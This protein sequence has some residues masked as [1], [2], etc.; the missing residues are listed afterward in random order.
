MDF[1]H[2][3]VRCV[4]DI[5]LLQSLTQ[6]GIFY[7]VYVTSVVAVYL[8]LA[9]LGGANSLTR[10]H[11]HECLGSCHPA[12]VGIEVGDKLGLYYIDDVAILV[13]CYVSR[14]LEQG[15]AWIVHLL[16]WSHLLVKTREAQ[17]RLGCV[18]GLLW[19]GGEVKPKGS[20]GRIRLSSWCELIL[21]SQWCR[22]SRWRWL[23]PPHVGLKGV[24]VGKLVPSIRG[25]RIIYRAQVL[26]LAHILC[27]LVDVGYFVP[28]GLQRVVE[29]R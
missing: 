21:W 4:D 23:Y 18:R 15:Y 28:H 29:A 17:A 6:L 5:S 25:Y 8:L 26:L 22:H 20:S 19:I 24:E 11:V 27:E 10:R 3:N 12:I 14:G 9:Q 1:L 16:H 2:I 7:R 13:L